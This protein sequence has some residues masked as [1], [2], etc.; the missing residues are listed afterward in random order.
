MH[1][2]PPPRTR[3]EPPDP[4]RPQRSLFE[5]LG[6][7]LCCVVSAIASLVVAE[8]LPTGAF[9]GDILIARMPEAAYSSIGINMFSKMLVAQVPSS[10]TFVAGRLVTLDLAFVKLSILCTVVVADVPGPPP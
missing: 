4:L 3:N 7:F 6:A 2:A 10:A 1:A 9:V 8:A 5:R